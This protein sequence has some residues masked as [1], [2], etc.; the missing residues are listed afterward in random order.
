MVLASAFGTLVLKGSASSEVIHCVIVVIGWPRD[1][2]MFPS[3]S[4]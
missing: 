1:V 4:M 2:M 3:G